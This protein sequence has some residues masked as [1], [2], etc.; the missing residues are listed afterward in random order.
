MDADMYGM[1]PGMHD[2]YYN[3]EPQHQGDPHV[4][5]K[6]QFGIFYLAVVAAFLLGVL[7]L[8]LGAASAILYLAELAEE[9]STRARA[10]LRATLGTIC[11]L[12]LLM[13]AVDGVSWWRC[14]LTVGVQAVYHSVLADFPWVSATSPKLLLSVAGCVVEHLSWYTYFAGLEHRYEQW[15]IL[16]FFLL[17]VWAVPCAYFV[18]LC[19]DDGQRMPGGLGDG[20][21][22]GD[23]LRGAGK[24]KPLSA[25]I[26]ALFGGRADAF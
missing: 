10:V 2:A 14:L 12:M 21:Q 22:G 23:A 16:S 26:R 15:V 1:H 3:D 19:F 7:F 24:G 11:V 9:Y 25:R 18:T 8:G 13:M 4:L 5:L 20:R 17:F 6:P